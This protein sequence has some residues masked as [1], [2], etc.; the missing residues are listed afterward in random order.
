MGKYTGDSSGW[1]TASPREIMGWTC[2]FNLGKHSHR[3]YRPPNLAI[4]SS[5]TALP[6]IFSGSSAERTDH[7][8]VSQHSTASASPR[9]SLCWISK[10]LRF[11][12]TIDESTNTSSP[13]RDGKMNRARVSTIGIPTRPYVFSIWCL[14][15]PAASNSADVQLSKYAKYRG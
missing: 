1:A 12:F 8:R 13:K 15:K 3:I 7:T 9:K 2:R 14:G 5:G 11:H 6:S 4:T 10:L